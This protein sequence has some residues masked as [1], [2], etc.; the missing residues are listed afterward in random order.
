[1][2]INAVKREGTEATTKPDGI[3]H[4]SMS[5]GISFGLHALILVLLACMVR[6]TFVETQLVLQSKIDEQELLPEDFKFDATELDSVGNDG[7][8]NQVSE[9]LAAAAHQGDNPQPT[10][11][12][13]FREELLKL[14]VP[15]TDQVLEL[16]EAELLARVDATGTTEH[17]GGVAGAIDRI[18]YEIAASLRE[19]ETLAIWL[20]DASLSLRDRRQQIADRF[21]NVYRELGLLKVGQDG[22]LLTAIASF[23]EQTSIITPKPVDDV[24][25]IT[26]AVRGIASDQSGKEHVFDAVVRV[27]SK[28]KSFRTKQK[29]NVMIII[30]TDERGDDYA[31]LETVIDGV[32]R[33]GMRVYCIGNASPFG[34]ELGYVSFTDDRGQHWPN[35]PMHQ[36]PETVAPE[37]LRLAFWGTAARDLERMS[38]GFGPY[39]LTRLCSESGGLYLVSNESNGPR[40]EPAVMRNYQ[41]DYRPIKFYQ[42]DL[43]DN[44]A[45][46]SLVRA[47]MSTSANEIPTPTLSFRADTDANLRQGITEA[48]KPFAVLDDRLNKM[49]QLL[50]AGE[51]DRDKLSTDR[52][53]AS[54]D[55]AMGRILAM[56][57][58]AYGY[59]VILAQMKS[60]PRP[61]K[62][63]ESNQ[64]RLKPSNT[65]DAPP[66]I[67]KMA[68]QAAEYLNRVIEE[69]ASTPWALLAQRELSQPL[70]WEW[71][72]DSMYIAPPLTPA[73]RRR[74]L[75]AEEQRRPQR[76]SQPK[77]D[78]GP[79]PN[80]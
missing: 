34:R 70:G 15:I 78:R 45:K 42:K 25:K 46:G 75:L 39:A 76:P 48:Q 41:P 16:N 14:D 12:Q 77:P 59:N 36:G 74:I 11:E 19:R 60:S 56:R 51:K 23:G 63:P 5:V 72:E 73:Q 79:P 9:S 47:A 4:T 1:M 35:R 61:F 2:S 40:F 28:W 17:P 3:L 65:V 37:R 67:R 44:L 66:A 54:Y 58:R 53:R 18:T 52:W 13:P 68:Q 62:R 7:D 10:I 6:I 38:A 30:V 49:H 22:A 57:V 27:A 31:Q 69:H 26:A 21:D 33:Y 71:Q 32:R 43:A 8:Q 24:S 50:A 64:W 20:F 80:L 29:R 55:L